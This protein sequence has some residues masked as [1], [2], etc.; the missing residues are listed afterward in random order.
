LPLRFVLSSRFFNYC[1]LP[2][3]FSSSR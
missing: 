3:F 2:N 1:V